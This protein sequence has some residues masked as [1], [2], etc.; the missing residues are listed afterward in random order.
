MGMI[1]NIH[2]KSLIW[3][4][5]RY[6][7]VFSSHYMKQERFTWLNEQLFYKINI[8]DLLHVTTLHSSTAAGNMIPIITS[9][10]CLSKITT[11][12]LGHLYLR[13]ENLNFHNNCITLELSISI[14]NI[15]NKPCQSLSTD[16]WADNIIADNQIWCTWRVSVIIFNGYAQ[17]WKVKKLLNAK[18]KK[19]HCA[20]QKAFD[21]VA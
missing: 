12:A 4:V 16:Y 3:K 21:L 1:M 15:S 17:F 20:I 8:K 5:W 10:L 11:I 19:I 9:E 2:R 6:Q 18:E 14:I 13:V 7:S